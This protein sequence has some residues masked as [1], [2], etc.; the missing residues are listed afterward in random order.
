MNTAYSFIGVGF[1][2]NEMLYQ[3]FLN[4]LSKMNDDEL[5]KALLKA[6]SMLNDN[7]YEKLLDVIRKERE[8]NKK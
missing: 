4:S 5:S 2:N 6:K 7:D 8:K 3:L 1:L